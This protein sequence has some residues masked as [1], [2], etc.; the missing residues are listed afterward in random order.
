MIKITPAK[1]D[2]AIE[3][4]VQG[5]VEKEDLNLF[6]E[7]FT[8]KKQ[9]YNKVN[10]LLLL[11]KMEGMSLKGVLEDLKMVQHLKYIQKLAIVSDKKWIEIGVKLERLLPETN[12]EHFIPENKVQAQHWLGE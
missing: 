3:V 11:D 5:K 7:F 12:V 10:I 2:N 8:M 6:E 9:E 1:M 4:E